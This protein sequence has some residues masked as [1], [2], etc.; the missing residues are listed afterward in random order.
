MCLLLAPYGPAPSWDSGRGL[1]QPAAEKVPA[2]MQPG[3][4]MQ[5]PVESVAR[6]HWTLLAGYTSSRGLMVPAASCI[7]SVVQI[8]RPRCPVR[9]HRDP[10]LPHER[11]D[12]G[13]K[14]TVCLDAPFFQ[15][16]SDANRCS[17]PRHDQAEYHHADSSTAHKATPCRS[18]C[19][20]TTG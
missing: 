10:F 5:S 16:V 18:M 20:F 11:I 7:T 1:L 9:G 4:K 2:R 13:R 8:H 19:I 3:R 15:G 17:P 12:V 14:E 6:F